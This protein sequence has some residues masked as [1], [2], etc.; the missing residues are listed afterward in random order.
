MKNPSNSKVD[1]SYFEGEK[2]IG[3]LIAKVSAKYEKEFLQ[4]LTED[5]HFS[6]ITNSDHR[7]LKFLTAN[8][9]NSNDIARQIGV[10][11]Q[12]IS[13]TISSLEKRG[14][15][16]RKESLEDG[17]SQILLLTEKGNKLVLKAVQVAKE[18]EQST[19]KK[20]GAKDLNLLKELLSRTH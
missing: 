11:K 13:K 2:P 5:K 16:V 10:S 9:V 19:L 1:R 15:I 12:A 14:F 18:L 17:R 7:V 8:G 4:K 20:L 6:S 3:W